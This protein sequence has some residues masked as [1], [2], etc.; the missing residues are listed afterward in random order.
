MNRIKADQKYPEALEPCNITSLYKHKGSQKDFMN[1]RGV[2]RVTV[3]RS[4]LDRLVYNDTYETIDSYLTDGNVGA[5]K[6]RNIRDN[7]FVLGAVTTSVINGNENAIQVQ[8][9]DVEKCFDKLWLQSTTNA[10]YEAGMK[11]YLLNILFEDN[12]SAKIAIKMNGR[13]NERTIVKHVEMQGSVW[14]S[15]KCTTT[16]DKL[17]NI[18]L[19]HED[20]KY[21]YRGDKNIEIGVLGMVDDT[22]SISEC[23]TSSIKKECHIKYIH[24]DSKINTIS[25]KKCCYECRKTYKMQATLP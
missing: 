7:I 9:L 10:L 25:R 19:G 1:Y 12:V 21:R 17:N 4:I 13:L 24:R 15:L 6:A 3:F 20:L 16:M 8:V 11:N 23:G 2:F 22:I 14:G 18:M 5:R